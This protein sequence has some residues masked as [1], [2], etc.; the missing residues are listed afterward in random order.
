M[1]FPG[2][3]ALDNVSVSVAPGMNDTNPVQFSVTTQP[4]PS[5]WF[6]TEIG[7]GGA[8]GGV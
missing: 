1:E 8:A 5:S 2:V 4:L 3:K 6:D 7:S